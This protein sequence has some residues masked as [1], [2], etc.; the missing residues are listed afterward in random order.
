MENNRH[1]KV[2]ISY[3]WEDDPHKEWIRDL[4]DQLISDGIDVTLDQYEVSLGDRLP[5]FMEEAITK[6]D[7]VMIICTPSYKEKADKRESG[8]GY[9]GHIISEELMS[10]HNERKFIPLIRKGTIKEA[11]PTF[12]KGKLGIN[13]TN[14][15]NFRENY[16]DL[17]ATLYG[18]KA[19]PKIGN[20]PKRFNEINRVKSNDKIKNNEVEIIGII[21]DEVTVPKM[22]G[23]R[24]SSLYTIPFRLNMSPDRKWNEIFIKYWNSPPKFTTMHR[25]R[26]A[27]VVG[28]EIRLRGTTIEEVRAYHRDTLVLCVEKA[29]E[30]YRE[31]IENKRKQNEKENNFK[32]DHFKRINNLSDNIKF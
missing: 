18:A 5:K 20:T 32:E 9:E 11:F 23:T 24:G 13:F 27:S 3:S 7:Y 16:N 30:D 17:L 6:S 15:S 1:I 22:D 26:I 28:D 4:A 31:I 8:V 21:T 12:L 2:F 19:K 10:N 29:N 25:P 14:E